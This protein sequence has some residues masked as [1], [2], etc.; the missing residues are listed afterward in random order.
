MALVLGELV[1][2]ESTYSARLRRR[3]LELTYKLELL[4]Y[5]A[6]HAGRVLTLAQLL[7]EVW[8]HDFF[9]GP[10]RCRTCVGCGTSSGPSTSK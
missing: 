10:D 5:L 2:D 4:R 9:G 3:L 7:R 6:Q 8:G 1:I